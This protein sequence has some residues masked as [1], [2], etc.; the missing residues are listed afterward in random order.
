MSLF[1]PLTFLRRGPIFAGPRPKRRFRIGSANLRIV[2]GL[3]MTRHIALGHWYGLG[4][5][6]PLCEACCT[7]G[8][9]AA[10]RVSHDANRAPDAP[11]LFPLVSDHTDIPEIHELS[12]N[13]S[14]E[15]RIDRSIKA[16]HDTLGE[17]LDD[18]PIARSGRSIS[19]H[20]QLRVSAQNARTD[21][22]FWSRMI[23]K[24]LLLHQPDG[25]HCARV[26]SKTSTNLIS[27]QNLNHTVDHN[28]VPGATPKLWRIETASDHIGN[29]KSGCR[30]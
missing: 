9:T 2:R 25:R 3:K 4:S 19:F 18:R 17:M 23:A 28:V 15:E 10:F 29:E 12:R 1:F 30:A 11:A 20:A 21:N 26:S 16:Y 22:R 8:L 5:R 6:A 24:T 7:V 27:G 14:E 13:R